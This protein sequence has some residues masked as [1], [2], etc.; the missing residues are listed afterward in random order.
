MNRTAMI[1]LGLL[2][3]V[4]SVAHANTIVDKAPRST[5]IGAP[6]TSGN[7]FERSAD[8]FDV[9]G[10]TSIGVV[11]WYGFFF[12]SSA[13]TNPASFDVF[14]YDDDP[15]GGSIGL[16]VE[17]P[18][19]STRVEGVVGVDTGISASGTTIFEWTSAIPLAVLP[20]AGKY[21][22]SVQGV[23]ESPFPSA[24]L[25]LWAYSETEP[26][27]DSTAFKDDLTDFWTELPPELPEEEGFN[28]L[29]F[30]L[31]VP[32]PGTFSLVLLGLSGLGLVRRRSC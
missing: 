11:T 24:E 4:G 20:A 13:S 30:A 12:P 5:A 26:E 27:G 17:P 22:I 7:E 1:L 21:W 10:P 31:L 19:Y 9:A 16:P 3:C 29:A 8:D 15:T 23:P 32:E 18:I 28:A 25:W 6:S 14:F 2:A